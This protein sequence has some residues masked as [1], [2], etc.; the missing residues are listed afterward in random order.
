MKNLKTKLSYAIYF[1]LVAFAV[2]C[3]NDKV[4]IKVGQTWKYT[5]N[6]DNPYEKATIN[7]KEVIEITG[8][9]VLYIENKKDTL[10]ENKFWFVLGECVSN[11][12]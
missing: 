7:Y 1:M 9:Y 3:T 4:S 5:Y 12:D 6:D 10:N 2:G 8:E 11:C